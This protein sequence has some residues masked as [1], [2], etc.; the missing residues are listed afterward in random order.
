MGGIGGE[1][2]GE[3]GKGKGERG[4]QC[5]NVVKRIKAIEHGED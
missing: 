5:L 3:G 4:D 1:E 2:E